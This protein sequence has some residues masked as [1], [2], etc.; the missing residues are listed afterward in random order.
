MLKPEHERRRFQDFPR[1]QADVNVLENMF[2]RRYCIKTFCRS[3]TL[4][5]FLRAVFFFFFFFF[6]FCAYSGLHANV[7]KTQLSWQILTS[8]W[9]HEITIASVHVTDDDVSFCDGPIM[10]IR[11]TAKP[12]MS[13]LIHGFV[14]VKTRLLIT[15]DTACLHN[16]NKWFQNPLIPSVS[17]K[18]YWPTVLTRCRKARSLARVYTIY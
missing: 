18:R 9:R 7:L 5:K 15:C 12:W 1:G 16:N 17:W 14:P 6:F 8:S 10:L 11:K 2:V 4:E 13:L 3:K